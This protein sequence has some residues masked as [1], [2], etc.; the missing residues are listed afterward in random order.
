LTT[1]SVNFEEI[2]RNQHFSLADLMPYNLFAESNPV[3]RLMYE[4][5]TFIVGGSD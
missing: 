5:L 3:Y 4:R 2:Y 1:C